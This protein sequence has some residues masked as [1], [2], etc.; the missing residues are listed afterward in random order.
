MSSIARQPW[1]S[2]SAATPSLICSCN[3]ASLSRPPVW[4]VVL[5]CV[6][7]LIWASLSRPDQRVRVGRCPPALRAV[8]SPLRRKAARRGRSGSPGKGASPRSFPRSARGRILGA[9]AWGGAAPHNP[10]GNLGQLSGRRPSVPVPQG[11]GCIGLPRWSGGLLG[12]WAPGRPVP[13]Q[14]VLRLS[15]PAW[16][17]PAPG[18]GGAPLPWAQPEAVPGAASLGVGLLVLRASLEAR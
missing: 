16:P 11:A 4:L 10:G 12:W 3:A 15:T 18:P 9:L 13:A 8:G 2:T 14:G 6:L 1:D 17:W 7:V 5:V